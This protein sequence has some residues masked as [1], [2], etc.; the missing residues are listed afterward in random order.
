MRKNKHSKKHKVAAL[1][2]I[3]T[4]IEGQ[5][6]SAKQGQIIEVS[7]E[8]EAVTLLP[9]EVM[10]MGH[11]SV[12]GPATVLGPKK[13]SVKVV[14]KRG[15]ETTFEELELP[16][17]GPFCDWPNPDFYTKPDGT[18]IYM[19]EG[20]ARRPKD[21]RG[22]PIPY[23]TFMDADGV[24]HFTM[25]DEQ[26]IHYAGINCLCA[27]CGAYMADISLRHDGIL[28]KG[29]PKYPLYY[30][31][32]FFI[33][34]PMNFETGYFNNPPMHYE[35]AMFAIQ[36]CPWFTLAQ[37]VRPWSVTATEHIPV[38]ERPPEFVMV[39]ARGYIPY[40]RER[41]IYANHRTVEFRF[42]P[43]GPLP[44][45]KELRAYFG[46]AYKRMAQ[47]AY[48]MLIRET[49]ETLVLAARLQKAVRSKVVA[50]AIN[51]ALSQVIDDTSEVT[52]GRW[53]KLGLWAKRQKPYTTFIWPTTPS[54][55][56]GQS[57]EQE[58]NENE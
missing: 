16:P 21:E 5:S 28:L 45:E 30:D 55:D 27:I 36:V 37:Y 12:V 4:A 15:Q 33:G 46:R 23:T 39:R 3:S 53:A 20:V 58:N 52:G 48:D 10:Q 7:V 41:L 19:P 57:H 49:T 6:V 43:A 13:T 26:Y 54:Q 9:G 34:E 56:K 44:T 2:D 1:Q 8:Q 35:C 40:P 42:N 22:I 11:K 18:I 14:D 50:Q 51:S 47:D 38:P 31:D 17:A 29:G 24:A 25:K 32:V